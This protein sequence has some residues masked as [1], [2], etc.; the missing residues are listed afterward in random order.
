MLALV[1]AI[2]LM[3]LVMVASA[4]VAMA[5]RQTGEALYLFWRQ[6][7]YAGLGVT[8]ATAVVA[9]IPVRTVQLAGPS[10]LACGLLLLVLVLL[11]GV[12][13]EV[14]GS[15]RWL[16]LVVFNLQVSEAAKLCVFIYLAGYLVR[17][18]QALQTTAKGFLLPVGVLAL[19]AALLL[20]E[21]DFG[22]AAVIIATGMTMLFLAGAPLGWLLACLTCGAGTA[23][24]L[25]VTSPYRW[26]RLTA[27]LNP[28]ADPFDS[29]F[30]LTQA[31]IAV[32]RGGWF[33]VGLGNSVQKLFYLPEAHTDFLFSVLAEELG[34][35]GVLAVLSLYGLLVWRIFRAGMASHAA[36]RRF[37]AYLCWGVGFWLGLQAFINMGVNLGLLPTKGLTLPLMSYGGSSLVMSLIALALVLRVDRERRLIAAAT[38]RE[39]AE[40]EA[41]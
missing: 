24:A 13:H 12:G 21:P 35:A 16:P 39:R 8:L 36:G 4:S 10:L 27:F 33:G 19:T 34:V 3:G 40:E 17:R 5:E 38:R 28:W 32:G 2:L 22:A 31:L 6:L 14:N 26:E 37:G 30:Q 7:A 23:A 25:V 20:A 18:H 29:G 1:A 15:V 11:P 9:L 41:A